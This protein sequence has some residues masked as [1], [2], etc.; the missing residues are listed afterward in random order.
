MP[1]HSAV[2]KRAAKNKIELSELPDEDAK[3]RFRAYSKNYDFVVFGP[4]A[5]YLL[6]DIIALCSARERFQSFDMKVEDDDTV[7]IK[8]RGTN[9]EVRGFRAAAAVA[10]A[11]KLWM[12]S[13]AE[14][15]I[16][17]EEADNEVEAEIEEEHEKED[18]LP[19]SVVSEKYRARYAEAG[20]PNNCGDWLRSV[21]DNICSNKEGFNLDL[22]EAICNANGVDMSKYKRE[23]KGD[24]GRFSMTGRNKMSKLVWLSG[25]LK[26]PD[27][28]NGGE[29]YRA[30]AEWVADVGAKYKYKRPAPIAPKT[31]VK[32]G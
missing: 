27:T 10:R 1:I 16:D 4:E 13:R 5:K 19:G 26:M 7:T 12:E 15:D 23:S 3:C 2:I 21:L 24:K 20:H 25:E 18:T 6:D 29:S 11:E 9:I 28:I 14:L 8:V 32:E 30:P 31:P 17:D 22:F